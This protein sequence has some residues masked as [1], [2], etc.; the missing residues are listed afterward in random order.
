MTNLMKHLTVHGINLRAESYSMFDCKKNRMQ[1]ST[2][3]A[4]V[5]LIRSTK[6]SIKIVKAWPEGTLSQLQDC[7]ERT[8]WD[9]FDQGDLE[10]YT[11][12]VLFYIKRCADNVAVQKQICV[13]PNQKR[14]MSKE[15][16]MLL[17]KCNTTLRSGDKA[18]YSTARADLKRG[19]REAKIAYK[20]SI[21]D[22]LSKSNPRQ[23]WQGIQH[24]TNYRG[25]SNINSAHADASLALN[26]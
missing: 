16:Q 17:K 7:F 12:T 3:P 24:I 4:Y 14:W 21:E 10:E 11:E 18:L 22:H 13:F 8:V 2:F 19:I 25:N 23:V 5:P 9:L 20:N 6:P 1:P 15:V 26:S